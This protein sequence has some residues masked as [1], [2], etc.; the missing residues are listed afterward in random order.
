VRPISRRLCPRRRGR[1][2]R[3]RRRRLI[4]VEPELEFFGGKTWHTTGNGKSP[5]E[6]KSDTWVKEDITAV[7]KRFLFNKIVNKINLNLQTMHAMPKIVKWQFHVTG[8]KNVTRIK[9][10]GIDVHLHTFKEYWFYVNKNVA[11]V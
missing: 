3:G 9:G 6:K 8:S 1:R 2:R 7:S 4:F 11:L 5:R 10:Q